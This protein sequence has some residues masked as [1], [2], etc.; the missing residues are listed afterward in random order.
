MQETKTFPVATSSRPVQQGMLSSVHL[1]L[2]QAVAAG[3]LLRGQ[4]A[5]LGHVATSSGSV[6]AAPSRAAQ[7]QAWPVRR[8]SISGAK[9][10]CSTAS[11]QGNGAA[12]ES[13]GEVGVQFT[14]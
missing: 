8:C 4:R 14:S 12:A 10:R 13:T 7:A 11:A 1:M 6:A 9:R 2:R 3:M 5:L